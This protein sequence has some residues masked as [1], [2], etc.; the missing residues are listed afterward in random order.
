MSR[1]PRS[2]ASARGVRFLLTT[3]P[4]AAARRIAGGLVAGRHAA[5]VS[6]L[7]GARS[8]YRWRG[9][10][11]SAREAILMVKTAAR[12]LPACVAALRQAHPYEVPEILV[13]AP[14]KGL[15]AY[16]AWVVESTTPGQS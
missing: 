15:P 10:V 12:A 3:A 11:E 14:E 1:R 13:F 8:T 6:V 5:C 9:K 4:A 7:P 2:I 16:V